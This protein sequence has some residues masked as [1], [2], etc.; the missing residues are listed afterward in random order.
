MRR[1]VPAAFLAA[2]LALVGA[3]GGDAPDADGP[4]GEVAHSFEPTP[5]PA[6]EAET[7]DG[8]PIALADLRGDV[9]LLNVWATWCAPCRTEIPELQALHEAHADQGLRVIGVTVD[10]RASE[11]DV[12]RF[13]EDFGMTYDIWWDANMDAVARFGAIGVPL[14]VLIDRTGTIQWEHL[15]PFK[16]DDPEL[17]AAVES[18][19]G[20]A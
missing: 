15:G 6:Y 10:S 4:N 20:E 3:C 13:I 7:L 1:A 11:A 16:Q 8:E 5:A 14:T 2:V 19:L 12:R 17:Q 9:V 18:A